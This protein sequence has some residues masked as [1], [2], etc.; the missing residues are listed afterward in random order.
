MPLHVRSSG[1]GRPV[2]L[3]HGGDR[4]GTDWDDVAA[5]L[6]Y[7]PVAVDLTRADQYAGTVDP[8][9]VAA[10]CSPTRRSRRGPPTRGGSST[11]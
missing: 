7:A 3:L 8:A 4:S 5:A 2:V 1:G 11:G 9:A 6:G 10:G